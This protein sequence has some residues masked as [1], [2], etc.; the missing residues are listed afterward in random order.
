[1]ALGGCQVQRGAATLQD[2]PS[3]MACR[4][5]H[6]SVSG[7]VLS[8]CGPCLWTPAPGTGLKGV[9]GSCFNTTTQGR[10]LCSSLAPPLQITGPPAPSP[11][12]LSC[13]HALA[14]PTLPHPPACAEEPCNPPHPPPN[15][16]HQP[17]SVE[18]RSCLV[19]LSTLLFGA[20][21]SPL[22]VLSP[23]PPPLPP[24]AAR[25]TRLRALVLAP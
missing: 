3:N 8:W 12:P 23:L 10:A 4:H 18:T 25:L 2:G 11:S 13:A 17:A 19:K 24:G 21:L 5:R 7:V 15:P 14:T 20:L 16:L 22:S 9:S 1:M 6:N